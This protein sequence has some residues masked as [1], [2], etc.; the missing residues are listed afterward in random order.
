MIIHIGD[1]LGILFV[2]LKYTENVGIVFNIN[3]EHFGVNAYVD[4]DYAS[5]IN[6]RKSISGYLKCLNGK[7][8]NWYSKK[9]SVVAQNSSEAVYLAL[10]MCMTECLFIKQLLNEI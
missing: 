5:E 7:V 9:Q 6:D 10:S 2:I 4:S 1:M 3:S 8:I